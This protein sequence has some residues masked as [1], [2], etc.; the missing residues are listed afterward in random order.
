MFKYTIYGD[1]SR[2]ETSFELESEKELTE[3]ELEAICTEYWME[4]ANQA[5]STWWEKKE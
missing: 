5:V 2:D 3:D 1:V 4:L